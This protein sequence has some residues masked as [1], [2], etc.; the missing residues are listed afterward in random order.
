MN[1]RILKKAEEKLWA[2][3]VNEDLQGNIHQT[4][5]WGHFQEKIPYRGKYWI[6]VCE[7]EDN[8]IIGGTMLVKYR[9]T[10]SFCWLYTPRGPLF[11]GEDQAEFY[12]D[13][14]YFINKNIAIEESAVFMRID[15]L[16][17]KENSYLSPGFK[18]VKYG[19]QP[20]DTLMINLEQSEEEILAN[21]KQKGRYNVRLAEK[22]D[23][24]VIKINLEKA[25]DVKQALK[26]YKILLEQTTKRDG[27]SGHSLSYYEAM[28]NQLRKD[29]LVD[30]YFA[31]HEDDF[32]AAA[33]VTYCRDTATYYF[34]VSSNQ[35]R[36]LMAPYLLHW[37][38][39]KDAKKAGFKHYDLFGVAPKNV[40]NHELSGVTQF[41][42]KLGGTHITYKPAREKAF[43]PLVY[44]A[45]RLYKFLRK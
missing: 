41:K 8:K 36:Q 4:P 20:E 38:I 7:N 15:P 18:E 33:I 11:N 39:T 23:V 37:Q 5:A 34:G 6:V 3:F 35:K 16:V 31:K 9:L 44:W 26:N 42:K 21:M 22:K 45:Y 30:I 2:D 17:L 1:F 19:F 10:N 28:I 32:L 14:A 29:K 43:K 40:Q 13:L 24:K 25:E 27:F 12:K